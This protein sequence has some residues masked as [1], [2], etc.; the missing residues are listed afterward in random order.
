M[1]ATINVGAVRR[2]AQGHIDC[3]KEWK[4]AE[5]RRV[6]EAAAAAHNLWLEAFPMCLLA[7]IFRMKPV[8]PETVEL[9][10]WA[11]G[12]CD[13]SYGLQLLRCEEALRTMSHLSDGDTV[14][15]TSE[16][17]RYVL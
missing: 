12:D 5:R 17:A 4:V 15:V 3:I 2:A 6:R 10:G 9:D 14:Q 13:F 7:P 1:I 8:T 11:L 16:D